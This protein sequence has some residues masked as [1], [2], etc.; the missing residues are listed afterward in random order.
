M[1]LAFGNSIELMFLLSKA[2]HQ[3]LLEGVDVL[4]EKKLA[5]TSKKHVTIAQKCRNIKEHSHF[6]RN[7]SCILNRHKVSKL[8]KPKGYFTCLFITSN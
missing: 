3:Y 1:S 6:Y 5:Q 7:N 2:V 8:P 4:L